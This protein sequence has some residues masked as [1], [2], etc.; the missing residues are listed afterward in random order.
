MNKNGEEESMCSKTTP[1]NLNQR[2]KEKMRKAHRSIR[3][4]SIQKRTSFQR[5]GVQMRDRPNGMARN[6]EKEIMSL[7]QLVKSDLRIR[8]PLDRSTSDV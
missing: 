8:T 5:N 4:N 7:G 1:M 6:L 2:A 3:N